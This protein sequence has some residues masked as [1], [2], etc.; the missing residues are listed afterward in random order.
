M[1]FFNLNRL[2]IFKKRLPLDYASLLYL[3]VNQQQLVLFPHLHLPPF[4]SSSSSTTTINLEIQSKFQKF[5]FI[6]I[7]NKIINK[8][9]KSKN[10]SS[11]PQS[12]K[13]SIT[14][15]INNNQQQNHHQQLH[16]Q[17]FKSINSSTT[18]NTSTNRSKP[19]IL[20]Q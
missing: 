20:K 17:F 10:S 13:Q 19:S 12:Q 6:T 11:S 14:T 4:S 8:N 16:L 3:M 7:N 2:I 18:N 5:I 9:P 1:S 15:I